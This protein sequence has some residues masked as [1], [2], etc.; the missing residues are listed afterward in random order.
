M[1]RTVVVDVG[2][3]VHVLPSGWPWAASMTCF[4]ALG[5]AVLPASTIIAMIM[6]AVVLATISF[7]AVLTTSSSTE[8]RATTDKT[9]LKLP[10]LKQLA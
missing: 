10:T 9:H 4:L 3:A 7:S 5:G 2:T 8:R 1:D 6:A